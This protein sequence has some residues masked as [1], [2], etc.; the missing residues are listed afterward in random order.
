MITETVQGIAL[1]V[2]V[3][4]R[5]GR[6]AVAG[7]RNGRLLIRLAATP[8]EGAANEELTEF[9]SKHL[10][11]PHS[12]V[13]IVSGQRRRDKRLMI[14]GISAETVTNR[15]RDAIAKRASP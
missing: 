13:R 6:S 3:V 15:L 5:A 7:T 4:P 11:V 1:E 9:L 14:T 12:A 10:H 2:R 8:V